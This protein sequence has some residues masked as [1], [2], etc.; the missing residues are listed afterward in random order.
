MREKLKKSRSGAFAYLFE[1]LVRVC[2]VVALNLFQNILNVVTLILNEK[3]RSLR[4]FPQLFDH[5]V[6]FHLFL[7]TNKFDNY[8]SMSFS[9]SKRF[10]FLQHHGSCVA[11][12]NKETEKNCER[13]SPTIRTSSYADA[14]VVFK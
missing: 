8:I 1:S 7:A 9:Y 10:L 3:Y 4:S 6:V 2:F 11:I 5:L 13:I 14:R 12:G